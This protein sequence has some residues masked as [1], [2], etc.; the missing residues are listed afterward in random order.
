MSL[1]G[2]GEHLGRLLTPRTKQDPAE[3]ARVALEVLGTGELGRTLADFTREKAGGA[4]SAPTLDAME[5]AYNKVY[6]N[7][8]RLG[9]DAI[10]AGCREEVN[11]LLREGA[12]LLAQY[13]RLE[14]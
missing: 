1:R 5:A 9:Q 14:Q 12:Q 2:I 13:G 7:W 4:V 3:Q 10:Y 11:I 6:D 8:S